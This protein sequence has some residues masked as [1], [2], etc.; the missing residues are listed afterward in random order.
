[1]CFLQESPI[2][3]DIMVSSNIEDIM[4]LAPKPKVTKGKKP[5]NKT[6]VDVVQEVLKMPEPAMNEN[7]QPQMIVNEQLP[8]YEE[9][10]QACRELNDLVNFPSSMET[11]PDLDANIMEE[12][13]NVLK[14]A[15]QVEWAP[16]PKK[17]KPNRTQEPLYITD[18][19]IAVLPDGRNVEW[20]P[21][22]KQEPKGV[23]EFVLEE[24][25]VEASNPLHKLC[26]S[27]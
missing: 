9:M 18:E 2:D 8:S 19:G 16:V 6:G 15:C 13:N 26:S 27:T 24:Y 14:D 4:A 20:W 1:M 23:K 10:Q 17:L 5:K 25:L 11:Q 3:M 7:P 22:P 12:G 21:V